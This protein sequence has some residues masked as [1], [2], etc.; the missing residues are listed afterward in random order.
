MNHQ[1][2]VVYLTTEDPLYLPTMFDR[3]LTR[4]MTQTLAVLATSPLY[5]EQ[6]ALRAAARGVMPS[7]W[8]LATVNPRLAC[9][10]IS[11]TGPVRCADPNCI[12]DLAR[13]CGS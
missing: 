7:F 11:S 10:S 4:T 6:S 2:N 9:R 12:L 3:V 8:M 5:R 1:M 13:V